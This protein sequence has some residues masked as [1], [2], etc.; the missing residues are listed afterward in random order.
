MIVRVLPL[1]SNISARH[2]CGVKN[3]VSSKSSLSAMRCVLQDTGS[4]TK[5]VTRTFTTAQ[6]L[7]ARGGRAS[8][9]SQKVSV[10]GTTA[11]T[12]GQLGLAGAS[13]LGIGALC[14]Y[15]LGLGNEAGI[16][17][18]AAMW[19]KYV[20]DRVKD[21]Y[22]YFGA[23][24]GATAATALAIA[25]NP[26]AMRIVSSNGIM[27][28]VLSIGAMIGTSVICRSIAYE[29]GFGSKQLAWLL[30]TA[31]VGAVIAPITILGGPLLMRAAWY[32]AG[33]VG[34]LSTVAMCAPSE[35]FLTMGGPLAAGLGVVFVAS[36]GSAFFPPTGA[37]GMSL[38]SIS[39]Y[40]GLVLFGAFLLYDTQKIVKAA[41]SHPNYAARPFDPVNA[42]M[43]IYMDAINI[44]IRIAMMLAGGNRKK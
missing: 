33:V 14:Y 8:F 40:G 39:V 5:F 41:E 31:V 35:K 16:I 30:H 17:D 22:L 10:G 18:K 3:V 6:K 34:G 23:S 19:P 27:A 9:V 37:L 7:G 20:R 13:A 38:Y 15:G 32:T 36:L 25:K 2:F 44:F 11:I 29:P 4:S 42:S 21:T 1:V 24:L 28:M 43:S 12:V 26:T